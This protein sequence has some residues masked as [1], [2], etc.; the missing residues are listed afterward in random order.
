LRMKD[1]SDI[2]VS[3]GVALRASSPDEVY[4][5][6]NSEL[7]RFEERFGK[8]DKSRGN[9]NDECQSD[10]REIDPMSTD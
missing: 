9:Y 6:H 4:G 10:E 2:L 8:E 5:H 3:V 1:P 7:P